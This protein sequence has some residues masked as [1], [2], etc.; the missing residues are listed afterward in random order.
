MSSNNQKGIKNK[1]KNISI[2]WRSRATE[3]FIVHKELEDRA[4]FKDES[5]R[6]APKG[7]SAT[8]KIRKELL[9]QLVLERTQL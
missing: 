1:S 7:F 5:C 8:I 6:K 9:Q 2:G 4:T 3:G